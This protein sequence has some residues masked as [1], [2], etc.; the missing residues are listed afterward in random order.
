MAACTS[1]LSRTKNRRSFREKHPV[2]TDHFWSPLQNIVERPSPVW[3]RTETD[4]V[5]WA[6]KGSVFVIYERSS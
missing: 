1:V 5:R 4:G 2:T 6:G 3:T